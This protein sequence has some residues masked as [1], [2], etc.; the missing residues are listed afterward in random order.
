VPD[1]G[2]RYLVLQFVDAWTDNFAYVGTRATGNGDGTYLLTPPGWDGVVTGGMTRI[3]FPTPVASIVGRLGCDGSG[4]L[5]A[6]A[7][8][9]QQLTIT[10]L[11]DGNG[12]G[13]G[14]PS[15]DGAVADDLLFFEKL[16]VWSATF[17]PNPDDLGYQQR[18]HRSLCSRRATRRTAHLSRPW[19]RRSPRPPSPA[20]TSS[21]GCSEPASDH[22]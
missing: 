6:V 2:D 10:P 7:E 17:P 13:S 11:A 4:D 1:T 19:P 5:G 9:Q 16:R 8:L 22:G 21:P 14:I 12:A 3:S 15:P 18:S 20:R